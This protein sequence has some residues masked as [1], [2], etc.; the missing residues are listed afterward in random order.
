MGSS[1]AVVTT[2][3]EKTKQNGVCYP[4]ICAWWGFGVSMT[5]GDV[6]DAG[7]AGRMNVTEHQAQ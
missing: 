3:T 7:A 4:S 5:A 6:T 2:Y 1:A